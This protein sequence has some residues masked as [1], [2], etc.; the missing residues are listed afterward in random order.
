MRNY[1]KLLLTVNLLALALTGCGS[2]EGQNSLK[3]M[4][5]SGNCT[6]LAPL[7]DG[8]INLPSGPIVHKIEG[9]VNSNHGDFPFQKYEEM[10]GPGQVSK[11]KFGE[12]YWSCPKFKK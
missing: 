3:K 11:G 10:S 9:T 2:V 5:E 6:P 12:T 7:A 1:Q 4:V 8:S